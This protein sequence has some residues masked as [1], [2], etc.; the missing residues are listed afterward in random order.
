MTT[1]AARAAALI[2]AMIEHDVEILTADPADTGDRT[3]GPGA[4]VQALA[5]TGLLAPDLPP[6]IV[7][8]SDER[9]HVIITGTHEKDKARLR[10]NEHGVFHAINAWSDPMNPAE[11]RERAYALLAL[12]NHVEGGPMNDQAIPALP[13]LAD[14]TPAER[15][16]CRWMHADVKVADL[17]PE[18]RPACGWMHAGLKGDGRHGV[19]LYHHEGDG[20][21]RVLWLCG[22][23]KPV[24]GEK[25][26]PRPDRVR[27]EWPDTEKPAPAAPA[28]PGDWRLAGHLEYGRVLVVRPEPDEDGEVAIIVSE[29][30]GIACARRVWCDPDEL[31]YI[32]TDEEAPDPAPALPG[33]WLLAD[34]KKYGRVIVTDPA[35]DTNG[36]V[37]FMLPDDKLLLDDD[38]CEGYGWLF[39]PADELTYIDTEPKELK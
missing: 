13:T 15:E 4:I 1:N 22:C 23:D 19:I 34:H 3:H 25:V 20:R 17:T 10:V 28:L 16:A 14:M 21:A 11:A 30:T 36:H 6:V 8:D 29:P 12:T 7:D 26:T 2:E 24:A 9:P 38:D 27:M 39:C 31:T 32:S 37:Y 33:G 5:K 18:E 35:P